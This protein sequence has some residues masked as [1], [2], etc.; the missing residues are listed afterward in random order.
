MATEAIGLMSTDAQ[1]W[2]PLTVRELAQ[3]VAGNVEGDQ[4]ALIMGVA[5]IEDAEPGDIVFAENPRFLSQAEKSRASAII[6]FLDATTPDK[7]LIKVENPRFAFI[8][9]LKLYAPQLNVKR[10]IHPSAVIGSRMQIGEDV[11]ICAH[12]VVGDDVR[13]GNRSVVMPGTVIGDDCRIGDDCILYP[14]V[15]LYPGCILGSRVYIHTGTVL[16]ADGFGY[17]RIG[18]DSVKVPQVGIVE[19]EDDVEIGANCTVD[20][21]KTGATTIG[22]RTKVDNLVHIAHNVSIGPDSIVVAQAGIAGSCTIGAGVVVAGQAGIKDHV[23]I[24]DGAR[25]LAQAG[26]FGSIPPGAVVSGY[27]ARPHA[28]RLRMDAAVANLPD[29]V[30]RIRALEKQNARLEELVSKLASRAGVDLGD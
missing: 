29:Y 21:S 26:V 7:P 17:M 8:K 30:K 18:N 14:H 11:C 9:I 15:T 5:S 2:R 10:G 13:I 3:R 23:T 19:I 4:D 20:R 1:Q 16:G 27:P 24:G 12:T 22:A 6:A 28:E 25:I